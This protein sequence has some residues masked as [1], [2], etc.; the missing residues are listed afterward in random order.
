MMAVHFATLAR[1]NRWANALLYATC[2]EAGEEVWRSEVGAFY[3]SVLATLNHLLVMD[4]LWLGR[5][6]GRDYGFRK[7]DEIVHDD[8]AAL[9]GAREEFDEAIVAAVDAL[10]DADFAT[11]VEYVI[12]GGG[13]AREPRWLL[14]ANLFNH[15]THHRGQITDMLTRAG[16][17][18]PSLDL[19]AF[20]R[21]V[22]GQGAVGSMAEL[23]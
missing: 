9:T 17:E 19:I 14:L 18:T 2:E 3:G 12:T 7:L 8:L 21:A 16:H 13:T 20:W 4:R 11:E 15:Q 6:A 5:V 1:Y 23:R 10:T 22:G